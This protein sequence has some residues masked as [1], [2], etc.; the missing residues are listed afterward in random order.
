MTTWK[1]VKDYPWYKVSDTGEIRR[2]TRTIITANGQTRTFQEKTLKPHNDRYGYPTHGLY[3]EDGSGPHNVAVHTAVLRAFVGD[4]P[5]GKVC[6]HL[7]GNPEDNRL[8][9]LTWGTP[10]ENM[11]DRIRHGRNTELNKTHCSRGHEYAGPNLNRN[12]RG[13]RIC[14]ACARAADAVRR[15]IIEPTEQARQ[16]EADYQYSRIIAGAGKHPARTS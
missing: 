8:Q 5:A 15:G 11:Q 9:N 12:S 6:R 4:R 3:R 16:R 14:R 13:G 2:I 1:A 7:N 10:A